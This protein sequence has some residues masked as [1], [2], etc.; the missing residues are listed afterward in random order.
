MAT[1]P[2][3]RY[4]RYVEVIK[5]DDGNDYGIY[6]YEARRAIESIPFPADVAPLMDGVA[7]VGTSTDYAREDH[8]H[9]TDTSRQATLVSGTN[10]KTI[11]GTSILGSG[12]IEISGGSDEKVQ[13]T[14]TT[15]NVGYPVILANS[16]NA[17]TETAGVKKSLGL[18][19]DPAAKELLIDDNPN[20][21]LLI[22]PTGFG[23][24]VGNNS[25][26]LNPSE[27]V[28]TDN[29]AY[30][31]IGDQVTLGV[32]NWINTSK[33]SSTLHGIGLNTRVASAYKSSFETGPNG[34]RL[35]KYARETSAN[36]YIQEDNYVTDH[37]QITTDS[38][39]LRT[40]TYDET[41]TGGSVNEMLHIAPTYI[42]IG[43]TSGGFSRIT[44]N[45][46]D[47]WDSY[48]DTKNTTG[49]T[50]TSSKIFLVG[51]TSQATNPV[52]YSH[53]T[54]YVGTDGHLY[55]NSK[56]VVNV[57]NTQTLT[58]KTLTSP[59]INEPA[60]SSVTSVS[61]SSFWT[62]NSTNT[63]AVTAFQAYRWGNLISVKMNIN[64]KS[65]VDTGTTAT[66]GTVGANYKSATLVYANVRSHTAP[67]APYTGGSV[68]ISG[69]SISCRLP[70][71]VTVNL[72]LVY[73]INPNA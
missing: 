61:Q 45:K 37:V 72:S 55:S 11:N 9:P 29:S 15:S 12:N 18:T 52:T 1:V 40:Y 21:S 44:K 56:Q 49:S 33:A 57:S 70:G 30:A 10:I 42:D 63:N 60:V 62:V 46:I 48:T 58:N 73:L 67:N 17:T 2:E 64:T 14:N 50:N 36:G 41:T 24:T 65:T 20:S 28:F 3:S 47:A 39:Y 4:S 22:S 71:G 16:A 54:A 35:Y 25:V 31:Y 27:L 51:A 8:I 5:S 7:T 66:L 53:D 34:I 43:T 69:D 26:F 38:V 68:W 32:Y 23:S 6:D 59:T 19:F 13:Q